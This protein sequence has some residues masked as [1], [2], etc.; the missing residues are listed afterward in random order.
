MKIEHVDNFLVHFKDLNAAEV[1]IWHERIMMKTE[2]H[3]AADDMDPPF[4]SVCVTSGEFWD[5][6][7]DELIIP[8]RSSILTLKD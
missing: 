5:V 1:F 6:D 7:E 8:K 4:N 3:N 2:V